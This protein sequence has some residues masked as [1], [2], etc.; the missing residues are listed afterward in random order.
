MLKLCLFTEDTLFIYLLYLFLF[1]SWFEARFEPLFNEFLVESSFH[2]SCYNPHAVNMV[3]D[4]AIAKSS[5]W[6]LK[7]DLIYWSYSDGLS[8]LITH[9]SKNSCPT[10]QKA[11]IP[12]IYVAFDTWYVKTNSSHH[13][14]NKI[15]LWTSI[16]CAFGPWDTTS[17]I[18]SSYCLKWIWKLI[19]F[20]LK[21]ISFRWWWMDFTSHT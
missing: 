8:S 16:S 9:S 21:K 14:D 5:E 2:S 19:I 12:D 11:W 10:P 7:V 17:L 1:F 15:H 3:V 20:L 13:F 6:F 18:V 4:L